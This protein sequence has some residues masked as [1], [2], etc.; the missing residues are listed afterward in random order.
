M[1]THAST[2]IDA[3]RMRPLALVLTALFAAPAAH[4]AVLPPALEAPLMSPRIAA[5]PP[6]AVPYGPNVVAVT[7]CD[8]SGPGSLRDVAGNAVDGETVDLTQL[9]CSTISLTTGAIQIGSR[10]VTILGP[11]RDRLTIDASQTEPGAFGNVLFDLGGGWLVVDGVTISGGRK[12]I[13][14][15]DVTGGCIYSNENVRISNSTIR[16]CSVDSADGYAALGGAVFTMGMLQLDHATIEDSQTVTWGSGYSS[17][18]GVY[19]LGG[20]RALYSIVSDNIAGTLGTTPTFGGGIFARSYAGVFESTVARNSSL[21]AGG[22]ALAAVDTN[23]AMVFQSTIS[24]NRASDA[25]GGMYARQTL[26]LYNS[27]IADN[28]ATH[29]TL[30]GNVAG[31]GLQWDALSDLIIVSSILTGNTAGEADAFDLGGPPSTPPGITFSGSHDIIAA[32]NQAPPPDTIWGPA[33]LGP[34]TDNGGATPTHALGAQSAAIDGGTL[35]N[36]GT[37][38][39]DQRG[40]GFPRWIGSSVDAGAFESDP[41][42]IFVNGFNF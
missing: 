22:M 5:R 7:N 8:D 1:P 19:A 35:P 24:G 13:G 34:L 40:E 12:Y 33:D 17:G 16:H 20:I 39:N 3:Q 41:D 25:I 4:A 2:R 21:R 30:H 31:A 10:D 28:Y 42:R 26:Y 9:G 6:P 32:T 37:F 14:D 11:G 38:T 15:Q 23:L 36:L 27:T 18:G 29:T